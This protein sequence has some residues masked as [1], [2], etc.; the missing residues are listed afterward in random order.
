MLTLLGVTKGRR[1]RTELLVVDI[2][3]G[4]C[5]FVIAESGPPGALRRL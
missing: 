4:S 1:V 3:G 2:G 5:E